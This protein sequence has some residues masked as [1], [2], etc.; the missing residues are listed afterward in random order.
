TNRYIIPGFCAVGSNTYTSAANTD[1][2]VPFVC[3][4]PVIVDQMASEV[5]SI[6]G[7]NF[8]IGTYAA[9]QTWQPVG[10]PL[11]DSGNLAAGSTGVKT[12][13]PGTPFLLRRGRY[14]SV[15][16]SDGTPILR[17]YTGSTIDGGGLETSLGANA[18]FD[19]MSV[20]RTYAAFPTPGTAWTTL[21]NLVNS[22]HR[23]LIVYRCLS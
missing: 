19:N 18:Y 8:R 1:Q 5:T 22:G 17:C 4:A 16:N 9:D 11:A 7:T 10:A 21:T 12:Y 20:G 14:L 6:G 13:T 23:H 2:Y 3:L 15:L